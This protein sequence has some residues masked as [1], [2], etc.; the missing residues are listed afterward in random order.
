MTQE[1]RPS[2]GG[3]GIGGKSSQITAPAEVYRAAQQLIQ[4]SCAKIKPLIEL[5]V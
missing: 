2:E 5:P 1:N 4:V 3:E